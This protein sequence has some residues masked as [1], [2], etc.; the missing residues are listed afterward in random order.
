MAFSACE[1]GGSSIPSR[2]GP[3]FARLTPFFGGLN[4]YRA[5]TVDYTTTE[6]RSGSTARSQR[7]FDVQ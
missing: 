2:W 3:S 1:A 4:I 6:G 5:A 7:V